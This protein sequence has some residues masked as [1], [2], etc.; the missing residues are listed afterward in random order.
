MGH[1]KHTVEAREHLPLSFYSVG[2]GDES[3]VI[4][5]RVIAFTKEPSGL[6]D[7]HVLIK[8]LSVPLLC[9]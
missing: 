1:G 9:F 3:Q 7:L 6:L 5:L 4:S 8:W 2:L